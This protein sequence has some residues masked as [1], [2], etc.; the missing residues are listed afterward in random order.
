MAW[1]NEKDKAKDGRKASLR[2]QTMPAEGNEVDPAIELALNRQAELYDKML[3]TQADAFQK[4]TQSF[5]ES[6]NTRI[7]KLMLSF[8]RELSEIKTSLE[9]TQKQVAEIRAT[10]S[11]TASR[12]VKID[13]DLKDNCKRLSDAIKELDYMENQSR[14]NNLRIDGISEASGETW[15]QTEDKVRKTLTDKLKI[16]PEQASAM[17]IER[18]HRISRKPG[19]TG[20]PGDRDTKPKTI[21][22]KFAK[23]KDRDL[24]LKQAKLEKPKGL[25]LNEDFSQRVMDKR[26]EL[27]PKMK[28]AREEGKIAYLAF[29]RLVVKSNA[30]NEPA[31]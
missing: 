22:V 4:V 23:F 31:P 17:E 25:F 26:K 19:H 30:L 1:G 20:R 7:D 28:Q 3:A 24:I 15:S 8:T 12:A 10:G 6:I 27:I 21:V 29:D 13:A 9:F 18:A 14:R 16:P 5:M 2:S 11:E